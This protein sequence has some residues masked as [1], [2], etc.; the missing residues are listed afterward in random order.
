MF[1]AL[2]QTYTAVFAMESVIRGKNRSFEA[3]SVAFVQCSRSKPLACEVSIVISATQI[4][5]IIAAM[6]IFG[7][8]SRLNEVL[9]VMER[10]VLSEHTFLLL[11][12]A[13][14]PGVTISA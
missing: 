10:L 9:A 1:L 12:R 4:A 7:S 3:F 8:M 13:R 6:V 5:S 2:L 11:Q 14:L